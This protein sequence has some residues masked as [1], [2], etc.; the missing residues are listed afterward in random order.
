MSD[1]ERPIETPLERGD[2]DVSKVTTVG[3]GISVDY[4]VTKPTRW[5]F[6]DDKI[7]GWLLTQLDGRV[8]NACAGKTK[9]NYSGEIVRNDLNPDRD[10]DYNVDVAEIAEHLDHCSFDTIIYDPPFSLGQSEDKYDSIHVEAESQ[11][12]REFHKLLKPNGKVV[13]FGYTTTCMPG[14]LGYSREAIAIFNTLGPRNDI[15]GTV[16]RKLNSDIE[17][18]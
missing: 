15:L 9:L 8:L 3:D 4:F 14:E 2:G 17:Q 12:K 6:E 18:W 13:Q 5:T 1:R 7:R 11:A 16:D 10:V